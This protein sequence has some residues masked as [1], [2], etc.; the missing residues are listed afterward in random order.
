MGNQKKAKKQ[1]AGS[2]KETNK[3]AVSKSTEKAPENGNAAS[4]PDNSE[5][6]NGTEKTVLE[7]A[8]TDDKI[9]QEKQNLANSLKK[10]KRGMDCTNFWFHLI[11]SN[12]RHREQYYFGFV[13]IVGYENWKKLP[14]MIRINW[15]S[16]RLSFDRMYGMVKD[17]KRNNEVYSEFIL[18][19]KFPN[20]EEPPPPANPQT[21][22]KEGSD[23]GGD[24]ADTKQTDKNEISNEKPPENKPDEGTKNQAGRIDMSL[25]LTVDN[26]KIE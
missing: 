20:E 18:K 21:K 3:K 12:P 26:A 4:T 1:S 25:H 7:N 13:A 16:A 2:A 24:G 14:E 19:A 8:Q 23:A 5:G 6:Q 17:F 9:N 11:R 10:L 15:E 22:D